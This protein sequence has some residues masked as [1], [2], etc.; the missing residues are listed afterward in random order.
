MAYRLETMFEDAADLR[1]HKKSLAPNREKMKEEDVLDSI[2]KALNSFKLSDPPPPK[3]IC[4]VGTLSTCSNSR[5]S[6]DSTHAT[7]ARANTANRHIGRGIR[8][9]K[10]LKPKTV[11][12]NLSAS[13]LNMV[14]GEKVRLG[15]KDVPTSECCQLETDTFRHI[16]DAVRNRYTQNFQPKSLNLCSAPNAGDVN[17]SL[18]LSTDRVEKSIAAIFREPC[19]QDP[20]SEAARSISTQDE[21]YH[22]VSRTKSSFGRGAEHGFSKQNKATCLSFSAEAASS[23]LACGAAEVNLKS[24]FLVDND[25]ELQTMSQLDSMDMGNT[26]NDDESTLFSTRAAVNVER[27]DVRYLASDSSSVTHDEL[28]T[29][30][31]ITNTTDLSLSSSYSF[32]DRESLISVMTEPSLIDDCV[33]FSIPF[34][35]SLL[36]VTCGK[37]QDNE[38]KK[39]ESK[40]HAKKD[41]RTLKRV[42]RKLTL[43]LV[44]AK[45]T[46]GY[47]CRQ[48][49]PECAEWGPHDCCG[50]FRS[51][52]YLRV[53]CMK[54][55][56][57]EASQSETSLLN[58]GR[59]QESDLNQVQKVRTL[60]DIQPFS[61]LFKQNDG[62]LP[63]SE[64]NESSKVTTEV[65]TPEA[66]AA[67]P[68]CLIHNAAPQFEGESK[69]ND[70]IREPRLAKGPFSRPI[71]C[72]ALSSQPRSEEQDSTVNLFS[73]PSK[74]NVV[75]TSVPL[76]KRDGDELENDA[77]KKEHFEESES[78]AIHLIRPKET[79]TFSI[80]H[81]QRGPYYGKC[82]NH[83]PSSFSFN[84]EKKED[85]LGGWMGAAAN[86][87]AKSQ[88]STSETSAEFAMAMGML[89]L[90]MEE[91]E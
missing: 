14:I 3:R 77:P 28:P 18:S 73:G 31:L 15:N 43:A 70:T 24:E 33:D 5:C 23:L 57:G 38:V 59:E 10:L 88:D 76:G 65:D 36:S 37:V 45:E 8:G 40:L 16:V 79:P 44:R 53:S 71:S 48:L 9:A 41:R 21:G 90:E 62:L 27:N 49:D 69:S 84:E 81:P 19:R 12:R 29:H 55:P 22:P 85:D 91:G 34:L 83:F 6:A 64:Y 52:D 47:V 30:S 32:D 54:K 51:K 67:E 7:P 61:N 35:V 4:S 60:D 2:S 89:L 26:D 46:A 75:G 63:Q 56:T 20:D 42:H 86:A 1:R 58:V 17:P 50:A 74:C 68:N 72:I 82:D 13:E 66:F 39:D 11:N 80:V 87:D 25:L 78:A